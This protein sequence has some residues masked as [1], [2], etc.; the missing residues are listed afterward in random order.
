MAMFGSKKS[1]PSEGSELVLAYLEEAQRVRTHLTLM[2]GQDRGVSAT[3]TSVTE[4][5]VS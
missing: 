1:K 4:D 3:L 5:R 2:D